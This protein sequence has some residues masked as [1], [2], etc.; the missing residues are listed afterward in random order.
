MIG[1]FIAVIIIAALAVVSKNKKLVSSLVVS[2]FIA[3]TAFCLWAITHRGDSGAEFFTFDNL[4]LMFFALL[5][6]ISPIICYHSAKY[7]EDQTL[8]EYKTFNLLFIALCVAITCVY[9]AN[10]L[11]VTWIFLE[12]TSICTAGLIYTKKDKQSLE[13]TWKY[14]FVCSLGIAIAYLGVLLMSSV[15]TNGDLDYDNLQIMASEGNP[16]YLKL[17]FLFILVG[18]SCKMEV[19]PLYTAGVDGN[20]A[21]PT[22]VSALISTALVNAGFIAVFRVYKVIAHSDTF[23]WASNVLIVA[24][25]ISLLIAAFF[26]RRT[27]NYKRFLSYSTVENMGIVLI[28]LGVGGVGIYAALLHVIIHTFIKSSL[29]LQIA[30]IGKCFGSYRINRIGECINYYSLSGFVMILGMVAILAFPPSP[31]FLT[32]MLILKQIIS[33]GQWWLLIVM[34]LLI[35]LVIYSFCDHILCLCYKK[36]RYKPL[37][38]HKSRM[39]MSWALVAMFLVVFVVGLWSPQCLMSFIEQI[40]DLGI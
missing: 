6:L 35:C 20:S 25:I 29:L 15:A 2:F 34:T 33:N 40:A 21:V 37:A 11:A 3:Q 22:P 8:A 24:G 28:G 27:N 38:H 9:F 17:A 23:A 12:A 36:T 26:L 30:R 4:G 32:E 1:Y 14:I 18:Y 31:L 19:F 10:H 16:L 39:N 13:A 7:I 5:A